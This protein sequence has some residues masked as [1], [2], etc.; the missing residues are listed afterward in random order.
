MK[1]RDKSR[2][3]S[4]IIQAEERK[5]DWLF[6]IKDNGIGVSEKQS[7]RIFGIFK[8]LHSREEYPG[9][10]IGLAL[11]KKIIENHGGEIWVS[12]NLDVGATFSFTIPKSWEIIKM[13]K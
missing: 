12:S 7:E 11:V 13:K 4:I 8:R 6:N 10:G 3:V 5:L 2:N 9:T 1:F